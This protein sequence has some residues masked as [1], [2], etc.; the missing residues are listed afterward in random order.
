LSDS[1]KYKIIRA[2]RR[3]PDCSVEKFR[4]LWPAQQ[5]LVGRLPGVRRHVQACRITGDDMPGNACADVMDSYFFDDVEVAKI[6][7]KSTEMRELCEFLDLIS[8]TVADPGIFEE[9][10]VRDSPAHDGMVRLNFFLFRRPDLSVA[11]FRHYWIEKHGPLAMTHISA[12]RRYVQ[13]HVVEKTLESS[14]LDCDGIVDAW[15]ESLE[16]LIA[17]EKSDQ[18]RLVRSDEENFVDGSKTTFMF[19]QDVYE[20]VYQS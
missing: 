1:K 3:R 13:N 17:T 4:D 14:T 5:D 10:V 8:D 18:H 20:K 12:L 16:A 6:A 2:L 11:Q 15:M 19:S 7:K 9:R